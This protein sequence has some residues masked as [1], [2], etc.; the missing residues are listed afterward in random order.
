VRLTTATV[1]IGLTACGMSV[2]MCLLA[3][4]GAAGSDTTDDS[5]AVQGFG[6]FL[7]ALVL[8]SATSLAV[9]PL[10]AWFLERRNAFSWRRWTRYVF[11]GLGLLCI[12]GAAVAVLALGGSLLDIPEIITVALLFFSIFVVFL[13]PLA[14]G[15][16][17]LV[18]RVTSRSIRSRA[19]IRAPG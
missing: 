2:F 10:A 3:L 6:I 1:S 11:A 15:W 12:C 8:S 7:G 5:G 18:N 17:F 14:L 16:R 13:T 9:F 19:D 4:A